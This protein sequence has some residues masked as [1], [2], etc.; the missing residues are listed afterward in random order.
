MCYLD[1]KLEIN[2]TFWCILD[3]QRSEFSK[4]DLH[5]FYRIS[6]GVYI[7]VQ[8]ADI[9]F[10][11]PQFISAAWNKRELIMSQSAQTTTRVVGIA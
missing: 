3:S 7:C 6:M 2:G 9:H 11:V 1:I 10:A 5:K 8:S 4:S